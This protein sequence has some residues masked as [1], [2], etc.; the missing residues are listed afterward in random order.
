[1]D[2]YL[3][4]FLSPRSVKAAWLFPGFPTAPGR[5]VGPWGRS[6][7]WC[8]EKRPSPHL[9]YRVGGLCCCW[10]WEKAR[11]GS[12][13]REPP[14]DPWTPCRVLSQGKRWGLEPSW[15]LE[16]KGLAEIYL[17]RT[18]WGRRQE[19]CLMERTRAVRA[20]LPSKGPSVS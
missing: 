16:G 4:L 13:P 8:A 12:L 14:L 7:A 18:L 1:M 3:G 2:P 11:V 15:V 10:P 17:F 5:E 20:A 6:Q 19:T 9:G